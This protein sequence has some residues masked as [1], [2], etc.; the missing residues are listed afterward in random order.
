MKVFKVADIKKI[1]FTD[2]EYSMISEEI[3]CLNKDNKSDAFSVYF[4]DCYYFVNS[5][6]ENAIK[7]IVVFLAKKYQGEYSQCSLR[8]ACNYIAETLNCNTS[9]VMRL[10]KG[11]SYNNSDIYVAD[12][13]GLDVLGIGK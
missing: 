13:F 8:E 6:V 3:E 5:D 9:N 10:I 4:F 1:G 12:T 11:L 2:A 7:K